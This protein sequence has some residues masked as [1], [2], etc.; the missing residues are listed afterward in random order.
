VLA[1][2][3]E[4]RLI[5]LIAKDSRPLRFSGKAEAGLPHSISSS[6]DIFTAKTARFGFC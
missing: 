4:V 6:S 1:Q 3:N 5:A 2:E